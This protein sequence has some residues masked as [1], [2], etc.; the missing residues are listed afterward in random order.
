MSGGSAEKAWRVFVPKEW[1]ILHLGL[2]EA[3]G[4]VRKENSVFP[5]YVIKLKSD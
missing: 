5:L 2:D 1:C 4:P 3:Y